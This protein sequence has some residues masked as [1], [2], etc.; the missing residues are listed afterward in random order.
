MEQYKAHFPPVA[1]SFPATSR[2]RSHTHISTSQKS[3]GCTDLLAHLLAQNGLQVRHLL[4]AAAHDD[5][6]RDAL[7]GHQL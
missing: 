6:L 3:T 1:G 5:V 7:V 2:T 4:M